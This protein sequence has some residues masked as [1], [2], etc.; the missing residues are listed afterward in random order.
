MSIS[1][2]VCGFFFF[3]SSQSLW[4]TTPPLPKIL[5]DPAAENL[6][7]VLNIT[8]RSCT[9]L[10]SFC[11]VFLSI[12]PFNSEF[13]PGNDSFRQLLPSSF[14]DTTAALRKSSWTP[15]ACLPGSNLLIMAWEKMG[16]GRASQPEQ[17]GLTPAPLDPLSHHCAGDGR[18]GTGWDTAARCC[19]DALALGIMIGGRR[20]PRR[21]Q[22]ARKTMQHQKNTAPA[23][24]E[25]TAERAWE[26]LLQ[27]LLRGS[28]TRAES[29][30]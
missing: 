5:G 22:A 25:E 20:R 7:S 27:F 1:L 29:P 28:S 16:G 6:A 12:L 26:M 11:L 17:N 14:E 3:F 10:L 2:Y 13:V 30:F 4:K 18:V 8:G 15:S 23:S 19:L 9:S 24:V 21:Y